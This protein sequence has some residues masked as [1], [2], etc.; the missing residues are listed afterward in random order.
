MFPAW[1]EKEM[2]TWRESGNNGREIDKKKQG[3]MKWK[4]ESYQLIVNVQVCE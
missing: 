3:R 1:V 4:V 2:M